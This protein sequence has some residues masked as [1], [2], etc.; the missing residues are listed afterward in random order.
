M[1]STTIKAVGMLSGVELSV[2]VDTTLP[3]KL[4]SRQGELSV[5]TKEPSF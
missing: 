4:L 1:S 2:S 5:G 3:K